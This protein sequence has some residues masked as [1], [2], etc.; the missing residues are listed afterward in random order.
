MKV[1]RAKTAGFCMGVSLALRRLDQAL[2]AQA[3]HSGH[4]ARAACAV[5]VDEGGRPARRLTT[6]G[7]VIHNPRVIAEY[8]AKGVICLEDESAVRPGDTVL[9]RAHGIPCDVERALAG[10][11]AVVLD[12]TCPKVKQAQLAIAAQ[13]E[14]GGGTLLLFGEADHPEVRGLVSYAGG[15]AFV[16]S[17]PMELEALPLDPAQE[18]YLAAQTTQDVE[19]FAVVHGALRGRLGRDI[20]VLKTICDATHKRQEEVIRLAGQVDVVVVVGGSNSGNT[21]RLAEVASGHGARAI[22]IESVDDLREEQF[23]GVRAVGLTAGA[24]TPAAHID[25]VYAWLL[26]L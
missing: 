19:A 2:E 8:A 15:R 26:R 14:K 9:I 16:F 4:A 13:R 7:P 25:A 5:C 6:L 17:T 11:G 12:A 20:P 23:S 24:S 10:K 18:Y 21:K 3:A 1:I 22:L